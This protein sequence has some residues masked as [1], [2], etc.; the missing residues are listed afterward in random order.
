M[1]FNVSTTV[2]LNTVRLLIHQDNA[3]RCIG[4]LCHMNGATMGEFQQIRAE[5]RQRNLDLQLIWVTDERNNY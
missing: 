5:I 2:T 3:L 1:W 4:R